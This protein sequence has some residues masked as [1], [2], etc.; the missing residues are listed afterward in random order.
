MCNGV[1]PNSHLSMPSK[2]SCVH[3]AWCC[4]LLGMSLL[5]RGGGG[6]DLDLASV[7]N[8]ICSSH[9]LFYHVRW[10][11]PTLVSLTL[12]SVP[13]QRRE[14]KADLLSLGSAEWWCLMV[15]SPPAGSRGVE[16]PMNSHVDLGV[17]TL[18]PI[19]SPPAASSGTATKGVG[20][21]TEDI[22]VP[23][24][25]TAVDIWA[26]GACRK[27]AATAGRPTEITG[28]VFALVL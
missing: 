10:K 8:R 26:L 28:R 20:G 9:P 4:A 23:R 24:V 12:S 14:K 19:T 1:L 6:G 15:L 16:W 18:N 2:Q 17:T 22:D 3:P 25:A 11:A 21:D 7:Y 13:S 5:P 27:L